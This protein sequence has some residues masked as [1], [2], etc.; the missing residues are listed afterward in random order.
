M[1]SV[2]YYILTF[3]WSPQY[4]D[5]L[6]NASRE[7]ANANLWFEGLSF[8]QESSEL[9]TRTVFDYSDFRN[10]IACFRIPSLVSYNT[11]LLAFAEAR[12]HNCNDCGFSRIVYKISNDGGMSWSKMYFLTQNGLRAKNPTVFYDTHKQHIVIHYAL[13]HTD[14][15]NC[16]PTESNWQAISSNGLDWKYTNISIYLGAFVGALPGPGNGFYI[17]HSNRYLLPY[18]YK[19]AYRK[20]GKTFVL[21]SDDSG[22]TYVVS[23]SYMPRMDEA[24]IAQW[25]CTHIYIN[26]RNNHSSSCKCRALSFSNDSGEHWSPIER[27]PQ[28]KEPIC[29]GSATSTNHHTYFSNPSMFYARSNLTIHYKHFADTQW[30]QKRI[31]N[32]LCFS[33]YSSITPFQDSIKGVKQNIG[34]LW[35]AC[36]F[37][38]PFRVWCVFDRSWSIQFTRVRIT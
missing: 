23:P 33:D 38:V 6:F 31:T 35:G 2:L 10:N 22:E 32:E 29:E 21:Y 9:P 19:T 11:T 28:L 27:T 26:M 12:Q 5:L 25:N 14:T 18:H 34:V 17:E 4:V 13:G 16:C 30:K 24:S 3:L 37:A 15:A 8:F 36:S 20:T 1:K 7:Y